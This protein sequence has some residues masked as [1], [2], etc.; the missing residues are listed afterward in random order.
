MQWATVVGLEKSDRE[1]K[2][3]SRA[4]QL[5]DYANRNLDYLLIFN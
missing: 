2:T 1:Q 5:I 4:D 3:D